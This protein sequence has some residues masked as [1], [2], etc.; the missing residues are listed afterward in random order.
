MK[1]MKRFGWLGI[2]LLLIVG[3]VISVSAADAVNETEDPL[4]W[5]ALRS[6][7]FAYED[8]VTAGLRDATSYTWSDFTLRDRENE[9]AHYGIDVSYAQGSIDWK[10]AAAGGVEFAIVRCAYRAYGST[11]TLYQDRWYETNLK[12]ALAAGVQV[13]AYIYSQATTVAEAVAE[14]EYL[15]SLVKGYDITMPLV[16][17]FEYAESSSGGYTGRLYNANLTKAQATAIC[18]AF[19]ETVEAAG[20]ESMVYL[21]SYMLKNKVNADELGRVWLASWITEATYTGD[22]EYWQCTGLGTVDGISVA[23]DL[24]IWY[25][26]TEPVEEEE[27]EVEEENPDGIPFKDIKTTAWYYTY[28]KQAYAEGIIKGTTATTFSPGSNVSRGQ[29]VTML[30]RM[31]GQP[32]VSGSTTFQDLVANYYQKPILWAYQQGVVLGYSSVSFGPEDDIM[33][34]DLVVILYRMAGSP[35]VDADLSGFTD[36]DEIKGYALPAVKWAVSVGL[37]KGFTDGTLRPLATTSRAEACA[38]LMRYE[39]ITAAGDTAE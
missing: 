24:D 25:E 2:L 4:Y 32:E 31:A 23:V 15:I 6:I 35:T 13:G 19:C 11:G 34:E 9:T 18:N 20:Y 14:A 1:G 27:E 7:G 39:T 3:M 22:Y 8:S 29:L 30:Y 21:N 17:D 10:A 28:L 12:G 36:T 26:A 33:R 5:R 38:L 16:L 37:L